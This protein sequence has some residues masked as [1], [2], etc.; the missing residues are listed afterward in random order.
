MPPLAHEA[1]ETLAAGPGL[2]GWWLPVL[3]LALGLGPYLAAVR[4][5]VRRGR[6]WS[7]WHTLSW[8]VGTGAVALVV[9]PAMGAFTEAYAAG[10]RGHMAQHVVLG[11]LAPLALVLGAPGALLLGAVPARTGRRIVAV[12]RS[13][14]VHLLTHPAT[15]A[16]L[17][18]GSM[19]AL[20]LTPL[21]ATT[22]EHPVAHVVVH[23]HFLAVGF[24]FAWSLVGLDPAPRRPAMRTRVAVLVLAAGAHAHLAKLLYAGA[25]RLPPRGGHGRAEVEAAAQWMYYGGDVAELLLATAVFAV[26]YRG[27]RPRRRPDGFSPRSAAS[28]AGRRGTLRPR[29]VTG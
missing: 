17:H 23:V 3:V 7:G 18:V 6:R 22:A 27:R 2:A 10:L 14:P 28:R 12:L 11:M 20:Y 21:Q 29:R 15:A 25:T 5:R 24:L 13:G 9:S 8:S 16:L 1:H 19:F 26:W 4:S